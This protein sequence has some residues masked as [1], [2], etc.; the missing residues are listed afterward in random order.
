LAIQHLISKVKK[1][2]SVSVLSDF[3]IVVTKQLKGGR[4]TVLEVSVIVG[5]AV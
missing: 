2:D 5:A 3:L 1:I 4:L